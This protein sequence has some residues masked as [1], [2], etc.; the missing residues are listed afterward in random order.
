MAS[1]VGRAV[2]K[3]AKPAEIAA[4]IEAVLTDPT[5]LDKASSFAH[6]IAALGHGDVA[7]R[8]VAALIGKSP[9]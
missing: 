2:S 9:H 5:V 4:A 1:G 8:K 6:V 3:H 7:A